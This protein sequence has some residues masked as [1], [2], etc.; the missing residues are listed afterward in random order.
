M[1]FFSDVESKLLNERNRLI[2][3]RVQLLALR[4]GI[5]GP[6]S[7]FGISLCDLADVDPG[8]LQ[9]RADVA[10]SVITVI[11]NFAA[12]VLPVGEQAEK[13][14]D[15]KRAQAVAEAAGKI[16]GLALQYSPALELDNDVKQLVRDIKKSAKKALSFGTSIAA[17][18]LVGFGL[19]ALSR[20]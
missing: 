1:S 6:G 4:V 5:C 11:E 19:V 7:I 18:V 2:G 13:D 20:R 8:E 15:V 17:A 9:T 14:G 3:E 12:D 10:L 16:L